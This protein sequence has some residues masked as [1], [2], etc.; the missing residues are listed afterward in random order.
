MP[1]PTRQ[2]MSA[3][4]T[5]S[6]QATALACPTG[7]RS[8]S[9]VSVSGGGWCGGSRNASFS[10]QSGGLWFSFERNLLVLV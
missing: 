3:P 4:K 8:T 5:C 1:S 2:A 9:P 10:A 6:Q 7:S